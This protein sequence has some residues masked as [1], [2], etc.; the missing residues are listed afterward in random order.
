MIKTDLSV[1]CHNALGFVQKVHQIPQPIG[2]GI[3]LPVLNSPS[4]IVTTNP[5]R[6]GLNP[7]SNIYLS[8]RLSLHLSSTLLSLSESASSS[9]LHIDGLVQ[10][11]LTP[12]LMHWSYVFLALTHRYINDEIWISVE[13][14]CTEKINNKRWMIII[15]YLLHFSAMF[16]LKKSVNQIALN[17]IIFQQQNFLNAH[18]QNNNYE[19][20]NHTTRSIF[21]CPA[22]SNS[23]A[24][25][26]L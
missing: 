13:Y 18:L 25:A 14:H 8:V 2:R 23:S 19:F 17:N 15:T 11:R 21:H 4:C 20:W 22:K 16:S 24:K 26:Y 10:E 5:F 6:T 9:L 3:W 1:F 7:L 12:L